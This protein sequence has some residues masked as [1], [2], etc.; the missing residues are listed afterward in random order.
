MT[1]FSKTFV[2]KDKNAAVDFIKALLDDSLGTI[3]NWKGTESIRIT[4]NE[5]RRDRI[6]E[7]AKPF[8]SE[9]KIAND[10]DHEWRATDR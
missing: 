7:I 5:G 9:Y 10:G 3:Y 2:C 8:I 6:D 4:T 1:A